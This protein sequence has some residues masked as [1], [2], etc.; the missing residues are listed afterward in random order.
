VHHFPTG[1]RRSAR[2]RALLPVVL[3]G[4]VVGGVA[5]AVP[6]AS[7][8]VGHG[9]VSLD[10]SFW[11]SAP[12]RKND[13]P[14]LIGV[15]GRTAAGRV[16]DAPAGSPPADTTVGAPDPTAGDPTGRSTGDPTGA[17]TTAEGTASGTATAPSSSTTPT[18]PSPS[19]SSSGTP[20]APSSSKTP[21]P[22]SASPV[23]P[24]LVPD[25]GDALLAAVNT[26]R[27]AEGCAALTPDD[28]L[29][30]RAGVNSMDMAAEDTLAVQDAAGSATVLQHGADDAAAV[31]AAW[32]ADTDESATL[33]DCSLSTA[34]AAEATADSGPWWT[35]FLA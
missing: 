35:L 5:I 15:D 31:V 24:E 14:V 27:A 17:A 19:S 16:T 8:A 21:P 7:E 28:T 2:A 30:G 22:S 11:A 33:L 6:V 9:P 10:S 3:A 25:A 23:A 20:S 29:T 4:L 32:L 13:S 18:T 12:H 26:A 1:P 34:G